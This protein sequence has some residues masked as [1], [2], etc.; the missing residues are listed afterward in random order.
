MKD[1]LLA[2][3]RYLNYLAGGDR[4]ET[5][6]SRCGRHRGRHV[7]CRILCWVMDLVD[8]RH[9]EEAKDERR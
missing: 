8:H 4:R 6:S 1:V 9:C 2:L 7:F 5:I 3:D